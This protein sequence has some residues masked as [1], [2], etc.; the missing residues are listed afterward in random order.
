MSYTQ[1][2]IWKIA[3]IIS[4]LISFILLISLFELSISL[5]KEC[6][7]VKV[8]DPFPPFSL[9]NNLSKTEIETLQLSPK[10][11][12]SLQDFTSE[13]IIIELLNVYCHTCQLQVPVFNQLLDAVQSD[14]I[15]NSKV[16]VLGITVGNTAKEIKKFQKSLNAHYPILADPSKDVFNCLGNLKGTPQTYLLRKDLS[17]KWY[18]LYHHRGGVGSYETYLKKIKELYK[19]ALEGVEPGYK[20]PQLFHQVLN[21]RYPSE[22]FGKRR[23]LIYFP[24]LTIFPLDDDTRNTASQMKV[25]LTL[26]T[27]ENLAI[28]IVG[29]LDQIFPLEELE[30][31]KKISNVFLLEDV[32]GMLKSRF[33]IGENPLICLVNESG[34]IIYRADSLARAR[35]EELLKGKVAQLK[36]NL[37]EGELLGL[38]QKSMKEVNNKIE[39][40][41]KKELENGEM[42][43]LGFA[44]PGDAEASL[45]GRIVSKYSI[46]DVCHDVHYYYILDQNGHIVAFNPIHITKYGNVS[47]E[48]N[49]SKKIKSRFIGKDAFKN[50]SFDPAIDAVSQATMSSQLVFDGLNETRIILKDFN[51]NGFRKEYWREL[52]LNNLC[53]IKKV[54]STL[55]KK[56]ITESFTLEDQTSLDMGKIRT[57]F[58]SYKLSMCPNGGKY[59]LIGE[60]P[61]CSI[62]GM[63]LK[64]CPETTEPTN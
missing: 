64:P 63:N 38:M 58:P 11:T 57:H 45:F 6:I 22:S 17:G 1:P 43:Y 19:S 51:D 56:G 61:I 28:M 35:A 21:K 33:E 8:G 36:P 62:H 30:I 48:Q 31:L 34:R 14:K 4:V 20:I 18:I 52:C 13:I 9:K 3:K 39:L 42:I 10:K 37:T 15:L 54:I 55:K 5:A 44:N 49:D 25:L 27:E 2:K 7:P 46:C 29:F 24:S 60:I 23:L 41:E 50:F 12:I 47:W 26:I 53:Q 59:L 32:M 40:V 16:S